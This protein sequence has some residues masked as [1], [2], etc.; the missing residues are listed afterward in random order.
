MSRAATIVAALFLMLTFSQATV[1]ARTAQETTE[2]DP[3]S[4]DVDTNGDDRRLGELRKGD[5]QWGLVAGV[6]IAHEIF[7]GVADRQFLLLGGQHGR[8]FTN[9]IG[10]AFMKGHM[11]VGGEI[12]PVFLM[13]QDPTTY[14]FTFT[15]LFRHYMA[16]TS[17]V[18]PF[19]SFAL[20]TLLSVDPIP[21]ESSHLN[22]TTQLGLGVM[23]FHKPRLAYSLEYRA[24]HLSNN[25]LSTVNPGINSSY[26]QFGV[27]VF[28]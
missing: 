21:A 27:R 25:S 18:K 28:R 15:L 17:K 24:Q 26:I 1:D 4:A 9:A 19:L 2:P 16:P 3:T 5:R 13:F 10:P 6:G 7:G 14:G 12:Y 20:G 8:I 11:E 22:F 23:W